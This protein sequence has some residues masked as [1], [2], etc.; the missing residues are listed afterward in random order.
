MKSAAEAEAE[1]AAGATASEDNIG[2]SEGD[3]MHIED[4]EGEILLSPKSIPMESD[5]SNTD[6]ITAGI[7]AINT[8]YDTPAKTLGVEIEEVLVTFPLKLHSSLA[9]HA[10]TETKDI[11]SASIPAS[12]STSDLLFELRRAAS[13]FT[14]ISHDNIDLEL[15]GEA[16]S[17]LS[18]HLDCNN[19]GGVKA[20][21]HLSLS[22]SEAAKLAQT[23]DLTFLFIGDSNKERVVGAELSKG[24]N[25]NAPKISTKAGAI[26]EED[27]PAMM[28][29]TIDTLPVDRDLSTP[30]AEV[31]LNAATIRGN[32]RESQN[33][34][35]S[36][37]ENELSLIS[38]SNSNLSTS[39]I[40]MSCSDVI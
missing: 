5:D 26:E 24:T 6:R 28:S 4:F 36:L 19:E 13:V 37:P 11:F 30:E 14:G 10:K 3:D 22:V 20:E 17:T 39:S 29:M 12:V 27:S 9:A 18:D 8:L 35:V 15:R 31:S 25:S 21:C 32:M 34:W 40:E 33:S 38:M 16:I 2:Y 7:S 23:G 1:E